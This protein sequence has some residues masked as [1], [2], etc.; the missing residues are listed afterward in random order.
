MQRLLKEALTARQHA[1]CPLSS[2]AV[3]CALEAS[4]GTIIHGCNIES[5]IPTLSACAERTAIFAALAQGLRDFKRIAV[6][7]DFNS[8]IPPCGACRQLILEFAPH[9]EIIIGNLKGETK[10]F[11]SVL[12][13]L[14]EPYRIEDRVK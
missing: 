11:Q 12:K 14:P 7:A 2:V 13:L 5:A 3:G 4:D 1:V 8:P 10:V 6:I 9:A